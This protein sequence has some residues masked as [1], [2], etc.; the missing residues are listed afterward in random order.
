MAPLLVSPNVLWQFLSP[1][2]ALLWRPSPHKPLAEA[3]QLFTTC[4][5]SY[6]TTNNKRKTKA[7]SNFLV[8]GGQ[9][10][11]VPGCMTNRRLCNP[12]QLAAS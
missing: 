11:F 7:T 5:G 2:R 12:A 3:R 6:E 10:L 4:S 8:D 1:P 9:R